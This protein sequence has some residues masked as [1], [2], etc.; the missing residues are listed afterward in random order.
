MGAEPLLSKPLARDLR[1]VFAP[2]TAPFDSEGNVAPDRLRENIARYNKTR[3]AG[4]AINGSTGESVLLRWSEV[5][6]LWEIAAEAATRDKL[7]LAGS[8]AES[9]DETI[10]M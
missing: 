5:E 8:G 10:E 6:R 9:T 1:G 4:Y 7:L 2:L 3:L